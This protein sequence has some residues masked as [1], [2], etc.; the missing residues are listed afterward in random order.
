MSSPITTINRIRKKQQSRSQ[1]HAKAISTLTQSLLSFPP[2]PHSIRIRLD[3]SSPFPGAQ[4]DEES[5]IQAIRRV[6]AQKH[7]DTVLLDGNAWSN[8]PI[9][10]GVIDWSR[11]VDSIVDCFQS[12]LQTLKLS[13]LPHERVIEQPK[14]ALHQYQGETA[15]EPTMMYFESR[16]IL[17]IL[18]ILRETVCPHLNHFSLLW[19]SS[20]VHSAAF[21]FGRASLS[22]VLKFNYTLRSLSIV[23][24]DG[25]DDL[26]ELVS[27]ALGRANN[28]L[29]SLDLTDNGITET[30]AEAISNMLSLGLAGLR[31]LRLDRNPRISNQGTFYIARSLPTAA[32]HFKMLSMDGC[33]VGNEGGMALSKFVRL[34]S[35]KKNRWRPKAPVGG[36]VELHLPRNRDMNEETRSSL[37]LLLSMEGTAFQVLDLFV[38]EWEGG[39]KEGGGK[40]EEGRVEERKEKKVEREKEA[41]EMEKEME[42]ERIRPSS[43][44]KGRTREER[45]QEE[46]EAERTTT[47]SVRGT[48]FGL[49]EDGS[50]EQER[51]ANS[52]RRPNKKFPLYSMSK[53][54]Y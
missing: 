35:G 14:D 15:H 20:I 26:A 37:R 33:G 30:G 48:Y 54:N 39:G 13:N 19:S 40:E 4:Q 22:S 51:A 18:E 44:D 46:E 53:L 31:E 27:S 34:S 8:V 24:C 32:V 17:P 3:T 1:E 16:L 23:S 38:E 36:L 43:A 7:I 45:Q 21:R 9:A 25:G 5:L 50:L 52:K 47:S 2:S 41:M 42:A 49:Y 6:S 28:S 11:V 29:Q 10:A 12:S